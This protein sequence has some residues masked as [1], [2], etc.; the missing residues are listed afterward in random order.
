MYRTMILHSAATRVTPRCF[1][2]LFQKSIVSQVCLVSQALLV[3]THDTT[4]N[5]Q[6]HKMAELVN[7]TPRVHLWFSIT[8]HLPVA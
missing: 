7:I 8:V 1:T 2:L 6:A 5:C 3:S 4:R